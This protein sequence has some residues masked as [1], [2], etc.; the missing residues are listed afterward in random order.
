MISSQHRAYVKQ[1]M[2]AFLILLVTRVPVITE[3]KFPSPRKGA[4]E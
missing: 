1:A 3:S 2:A 4:V